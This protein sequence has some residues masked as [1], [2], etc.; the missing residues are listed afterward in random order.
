MDNASSWHRNDF[1]FF[2]RPPDIVWAGSNLCF[3]IV[4]ACLLAFILAVIFVPKNGAL[5]GDE[6]LTSQDE[7]LWCNWKGF[8]ELKRSCLGNTFSLKIKRRK[9]E[10]FKPISLSVV[11]LDEF[12]EMRASGEGA[13]GYNDKR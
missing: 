4:P 7:A 1:V 13:V 11:A 3:I 8:L 5:N 12:I 9:C 6:V 10:C 2:L